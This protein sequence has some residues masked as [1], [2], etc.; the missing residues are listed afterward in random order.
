MGFDRCGSLPRCGAPRSRRPRSA[1]SNRSRSTRRSARRTRHRARAAA[2]RT[3]RRRAR[4]RRACAAR[5]RARAPV[6]ARHRDGTASTETSSRLAHARHSPSLAGRRRSLGQFGCIRCHC[7]GA[8][9]ISASNSWASTWVI[10][11]TSSRN[12]PSRATGTGGR[13]CAAMVAARSK[14]DRRRQQRRP[15]PQGERRRAARQRRALAEELHV[16][17]V[18]GQIAVAQQADDAVVA[19]RL[20]HARPTHRDRAGRRRA[21]ARGAGRRTTRTAPAARSAPR[22]RACDGPCSAIHAAAYSHPPRCGRARIT[23][24]PARS[25]CSM[26][27]YPSIVKCDGTSPSRT[28]AREPQQLEPVARVRVERAGDGGAGVEPRRVRG[29]ALVPR[30]E[31]RGDPAWTNARPCPRRPPGARR[32]EGATSRRS[33]PRRGSSRW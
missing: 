1:R 21:R 22:P 7:S 19:Q 33:Q 16:D 23:P 26:C 25:P 13:T 30:D 18:A 8:A 9:R 2:R 15:C 29:T 12:R 10:R 27:S 17:A 6:P 28:V 14:V 3:A 32:R 5:A 24:L 20:Q 4:R 31:W 11:A